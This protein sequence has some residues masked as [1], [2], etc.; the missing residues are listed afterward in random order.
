MIKKMHKKCDLV[1]CLNLFLFYNCN[2]NNKNKKRNDAYYNR[3]G[4][5]C[6]IMCQITFLLNWLRKYKYVNLTEL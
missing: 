2:K 1:V 3:T 6:C 4:I 5:D